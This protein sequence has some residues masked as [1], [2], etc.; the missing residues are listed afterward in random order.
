MGEEIVNCSEF[1]N[2]SEI[3]IFEGI[4]SRN[5]VLLQILGLCS[6]FTMEFLLGVFFGAKHG[7]LGFVRVGIE[8]SNPQAHA[9]LA[10][11]AEDYSR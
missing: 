8:A 9:A 5:R 1:I 7:M 4:T 6:S 3:F 2:R 10:K 11:W